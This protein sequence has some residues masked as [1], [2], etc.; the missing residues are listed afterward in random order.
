MVEYVSLVVASL[1]T[2]HGIVKGLIELDK[3]VTVQTKASE[4]LSVIIETQQA[5]LSIQTDYEMLLKEKGRLEQ[6]IK[7]FEDWEK[8]KSQYDLIKL[9]NFQFVRIPNKTHPSPEPQRY[10]CNKCFE[11]KKES[12]LQ[13]RYENDN[14]LYLKCFHCNSDYEIPK[15]TRG[16][17][18]NQDGGS[19]MSK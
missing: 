11:N 6:I 15:T 3:N 8:Q 16:R 13:G 10:L 12:I 14:S 9:S 7:D 4:L 2:A 19:W 5:V 17:S 1:K 18:H